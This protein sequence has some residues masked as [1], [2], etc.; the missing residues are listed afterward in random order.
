MNI[1]Y[2]IGET[3]SDFADFDCRRAEKLSYGRRNGKIRMASCTKYG[4]LICESLRK[5]LPRQDELLQSLDKLPENNYNEFRYC[6][7]I[8]V[9]FVS[10]GMDAVL[11][12]LRD[13]GYRIRAK[14]LRH[15]SSAS[16]NVPYTV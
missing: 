11:A 1:I 3:S 12:E 8:Y 4:S 2:I 9:Y 5:V 16:A 6:I 10:D 15:G 7:V 14:A 13:T